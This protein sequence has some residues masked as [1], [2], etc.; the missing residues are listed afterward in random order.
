MQDLLST[1]LSFFSSRKIR[2]SFL[3]PVTIDKE[4][5]TILPNGKKDGAYTLCDRDGDLVV[6]GMYTN[7]KKQG[8]WRKW[9]VSGILLLEEQYLDDVRTGRYTE[10]SVSGEVVKQ[11][12]FGPTGKE[13]GVWWSICDRGILEHNYVNGQKDGEQRL[14]SDKHQLLEQCAYS[15]GVRNGPWLKWS[16]SG[17][18]LV[19][20]EFTN[21]TLGVLVKY[22]RENDSM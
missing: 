6:K 10:W 12:N 5:Y 19:E 22:N 20:G 18:P 7:G 17:V 2:A 9:T 1:Y 3:T 21:G 4:T 13:E 11:G 8:P 14:W 15:D 16:R